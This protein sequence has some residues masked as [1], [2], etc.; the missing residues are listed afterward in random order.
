MS[1]LSVY[2]TCPCLVSW[3]YWIEAVWW[4][5]RL[6]L[7]DARS[8]STLKRERPDLAWLGVAAVLVYFLELGSSYE[9]KLI[10]SLG[11]LLAWFYWGV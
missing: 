9:D 3:I 5:L 2:Y 10:L 8:S 7:S 11:Y 6:D 4:F 1:T